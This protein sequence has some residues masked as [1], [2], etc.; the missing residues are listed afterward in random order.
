M[1][2]EGTNYVVMLINADRFQSRMYLI[3]KY[4]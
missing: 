3:I 4:C 2:E 1:R